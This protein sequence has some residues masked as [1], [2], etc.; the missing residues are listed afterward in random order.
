[1]ATLGFSA[2][3]SQ[4]KKTFVLKHFGNFILI[5]ALNFKAVF[6]SVKFYAQADFLELK[7][8]LGKI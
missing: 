7:I 8:L 5:D 3:K 4:Q 6:H 1:M 2:F